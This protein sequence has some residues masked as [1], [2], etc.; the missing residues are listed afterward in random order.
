MNKRDQLE[1]DGNSRR[2]RNIAFLVAGI[3]LG[4]G[5]AFLSARSSGEELRHTITRE[6]RKASRKIG[7]HTEDFRDR[8]QQMLEHAQN[9]RELGSKLLSV[10]RA[11]KAA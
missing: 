7:R 11:K 5:I 4:S 10:G 2:R 8:A 3:G 9:L 1:K 6:Y